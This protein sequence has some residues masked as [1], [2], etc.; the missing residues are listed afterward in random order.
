MDVLRQEDHKEGCDQVINALD[1]ATGRVADGPDEQ[2]T[3]KDLE[4]MK[5]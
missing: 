1:I 4:G 5:Q 2:D 3:L